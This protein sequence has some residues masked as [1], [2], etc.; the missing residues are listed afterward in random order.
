MQPGETISCS[1]SPRVARLVTFEE[2]H[3]LAV[4]K[5]KLGLTDR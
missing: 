2:R 5:S 1:R 3:H 4:L